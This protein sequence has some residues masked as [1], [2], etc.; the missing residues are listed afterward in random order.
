MRPIPILFALVALA[1]A[2][3][4]AAADERGADLFRL[5]VQCHGPSG[6]G[7]EMALA[8]AIAGLDE[9][10]VK[11]QLTK[12]RSGARGAH[13][14]DV[15]G[16][17][18]R[19]MALSLLNDE[20]VAAVAT[21][22]A[23][24]PRTHPKPTLEGGDAARGQVLYAPCAACHGP[25]GAGIQALEGAPLRGTS[26]WYLLRQLHNFRAGIRGSKPEDAGGSR[27]RPMS[28]TLP[29]DQAMKDVIA[30]IE[31]LSGSPH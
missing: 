7:D 10:Y 13:F 27:M 22:V 19:P 26:D 15:A 28:L 4:A 8:P 9:W 14:D 6:G 29:D 25:D 2:P 12:F 20:N 17:R 30:Y 21:Y 11:A 3:L 5:C 16:L 1:A 24:L 31:T 23:A 18:M